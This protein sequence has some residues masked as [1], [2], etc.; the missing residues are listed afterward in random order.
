MFIVI[1]SACLPQAGSQMNLLL[2]KNK[3][4]QIRNDTL[5]GFAAFRWVSEV[6]WTR[7]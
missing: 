1:P 6:V 3:K 5:M 4:L 7:R 2:E